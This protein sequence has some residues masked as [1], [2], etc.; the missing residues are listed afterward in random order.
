MHT[1]PSS[2]RISPA[3]F[4]AL[5]GP[6]SYAIST[7][8]LEDCRKKCWK[9]KEHAEASAARFFVEEDLQFANEDR[10]IGCSKPSC[11]CCNLYLECLSG[12]LERRPCHG[13][14]WAQWCLP[15]GSLPTDEKQISI[16]KRMTSRLQSEIA[17]EISSASKG[18]AHTHD[19]STDV[20]S[21]FAPL[22]V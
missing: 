1:L 20:S 3:A 14:A 13:N 6:D 2:L 11:M 10:Y 21:I 9:L 19:S 8:K 7:A 22:S 17:I 15:R 18:H 4:C 12:D 5:F 16:L